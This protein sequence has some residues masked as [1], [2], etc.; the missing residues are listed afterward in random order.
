M[1]QYP[2]NI[3]LSS[4]NGST[5]FRLSGVSSFDQSG[6]SVASAGDVNG[7]GFDD[8]IVGAISADGNSSFSGASYVVFGKASGFASNLDLSSL[9]GSTGFKLSGAATN[10]GSGWSVASAGDVNGDGFAD[11]IVGAYAADPHGNYSG[12]SYVVFGR[13]P[14]TAVVRGDTDASQ[15]ISGGNFNDVLA[16]LGGNDDLNGNGGRDTLIGGDGNNSLRGGAGADVMQGDAGNDTYYV[17]DAGDLVTEV[18]NEGTD[19]VHTTMSLV[20]GQHVEILIADSDAGPVLRG[21]GLN[22]TVTGGDGNDVL[23]GGTGVDS[24]SGGA[25]DD[26]IYVDDVDDFASGGSGI[27]TVH[28]SSDFVITNSVE[29]LFANADSG[30]NLVGS[31]LD[32]VIRGGGGNDTIIGTGGRDVMTGGGGSDTF[33][34]ELLSDSVTGGGRDRIKDFV[35]GSDKIDLAAIDANA[36][37]ANDQAFSFIG[38]GAFSHTAGELRASAFGANTLVSGDVDGNGKADFHI[39]LS[40]S[41]ALQATDFLL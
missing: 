1:P 15:K 33:V 34:F 26:V 36:G 16:G 21:N 2:S 3:D 4:L 11:L 28:A 22:N 13:A 9:D 37:A 30:L 27:D 40:G 39:L 29:R 14:D 17:D 35:A 19:T 10:D 7:D 25:G 18:A 23:K 24:M 20:L 38:S 12:E 6:M 31:A 32:N 5:G 8:V 41:V